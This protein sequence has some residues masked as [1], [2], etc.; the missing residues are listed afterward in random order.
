MTVLQSFQFSFVTT[1]PGQSVRT[2]AVALT[3]RL[4]RNAVVRDLK[5]RHKMIVKASDLQLV[6][7]EVV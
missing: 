2:S 4:A 6:G 3:E 1:V 7:C 5:D